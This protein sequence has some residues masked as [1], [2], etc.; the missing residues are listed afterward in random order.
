MLRCLTTSRPLC[1][2]LLLNLIFS[3]SVLLAAALSADPAIADPEAGPITMKVMA[4]GTGVPLRR[5][6]AKL[7]D[8]SKLYSDKDGNLNIRVPSGAERFELYRSGFEPLTVQVKDLS[9]SQPN[10]IYLLHA[11]P[12]D[13]NE[14]VVRGEKPTEAS[15]KTV[16]TEEAV[17]VAPG[18]DPAQIPRLLPGV[19]VNNFRTDI[20]IRG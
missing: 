1:L 11:A 2:R 5:V 6:E 14:I 16:T 9:V 17:R 18:R 20:V 15:R 12:S 3:W 7:S 13:S 19:Q 10:A 8:G 4:K